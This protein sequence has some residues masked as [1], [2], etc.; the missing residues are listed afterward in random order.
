MLRDYQEE[1]LASV[2]EAFGRGVWSQVVVLPTGSGK[3]VVFAHLPHAMRFWLHEFPDRQQKM[4]VLAHREE[5]LEQAARKLDHYNPDLRVGMEAAGKRASPMDDVVVTSVQTLSARG[6]KRLQNLNPDEFRIVVVDEAHHAPAASY[7]TVLKHFGLVPD[8]T[9]MMGPGETM[10]AEHYRQ[11]YRDWWSKTWPNKLL[12]GVTATPNR[13]DAIGLEWTFRELVYEKT[14]RWMVAQGYLVPPVG[15][16]VDTDVSLDTVKMTAGDFNISGLAKAVNTPARNTTAVQAWLARAKGRRTLGFT[17]D[18]QH[19]RDMAAMFNSEGVKAAWVSGDG[20]G[21]WISGNT[22]REAI[23][24]LFRGSAYDVLCN[25]QL[26]TEGFDDPMTECIL[27]ARPTTSQTLYMQMLGRGLRPW[28]SK[29]DCIVLDMVDVARKHSLVTA[30]DLFGLPKAFNAKGMKLTALADMIDHALETQPDL[31]LP[32]GLDVESFSKHVKKFNIWSVAESDTANRFGRLRWIE[33]GKDHFRLALPVRQQSD[34][35]LLSG[36]SGSAECLD[37]TV[38][39]LG[40]WSVRL[41]TGHTSVPIAETDDVGGAFLRAERW[42]EH[43]RADAWRM[44]AK[45]AAWRDR[46]PSDKQVAL[47][48]RLGAPLPTTRGQASDMLDQF[49]GAKK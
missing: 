49:Y 1:A 29:E 35:A 11:V 17:V 48:K 18:V 34:G 45:D 9:E 27:M 42:V 21:D 47:L 33:S 38:G 20:G 30:G 16:H 14:I 4:L 19:A 5:L 8:M 36:K 40:C 41:F 46:P 25:C 10:N 26:L 31:P 32:A 12:V 28:E 6:G 39:T 23:V 13:A 7:Q 44:K 15:Y 24:A 37:I 22:T 43:N 2:N 3:T